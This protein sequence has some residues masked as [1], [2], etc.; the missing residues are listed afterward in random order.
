MRTA[1]SRLFAAAASGAALVIV[2]GVAGC[3]GTGYSKAPPSTTPTATG[4]WT[5]SDTVTGQGVIGYID[6]A[7]TAVII[8]ADGV[9]FVGPTQLS[10]DT[11]IAAVIGYSNFPATFTDGSNYGLGTLNGTVASGSTLTLTLS[12]TTNGGTLLTDSWSLTYSALSTSGS[13]LSTLAANYTDSASGSVL[14]ISANGAMSSQNATT[15]CVLNGTASIIDSAYD[16]YRVTITY[17]NCTGSYA[18]LNGVQLTGV[19]VLN[20]STSPSQLTIEV[21]GASTTAK[22]ALLLNLAA[23]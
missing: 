14:S 23:S 15:G 3:K 5:G 19:A 18:P 9:Q 20:S 16:I 12:F 22:F 21:A 4:I 10:G 7:G 17:G 8:R 11:L 1:R 6:T 13:S 2:L